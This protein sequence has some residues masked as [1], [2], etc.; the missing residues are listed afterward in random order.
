VKIRPKIKLFGYSTLIYGTANLLTKLVVITLVP[1]YTTYLS[2]NEVGLIVF[3]EMIE[4]FVVT[5]IPIGCINAMWRFLAEEKGY[6][7]NKIIISAFTVIMVSGLVIIFLLLFFQN[8]ISSFFGI[9]NDN[10]L[11]VFVFVS[12]FLQ[13]ISHFIYSLLQYKNQSIFYLIL[14]LVQFLSL[15]GLTIYLIV[16]SGQGIIGIYYAKTSVFFA[17][18]ICIIFI[19]IKNTRALPSF[20]FIKKILIFGLPMIP[21]MLLMP[22]LNV[23]DR[24]F[25]KLFTSLEEIGRYGIAYKFGMLIN[26]FLVIPINRSWG[27]QMFQVG[28]SK[29]EN[30]KIHQDLTFYYSYIGWFI[31]VGLSFFSDTIISIV[32]NKEYLAAAW[33]IPWVSLAYFVGGFKIFFL[34][35]ATLADRT[36]LLVKTGLL[37][38]ITNVCLNYFFI[39]NYGVEGAVLSTILSNLILILLLLNFTKSVNQFSWPMKKIVHGAI[40]AS[41][42]III[43]KTIQEFA[44]DYIFVVKCLLLIM[45]PILSIFTN[46]IGEKEMNGVRYLWS[47]ILKKVKFNYE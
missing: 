41:L 46:L 21:M 47:S 4:L 5:I 38:I 14:S 6:N 37:A 26:M 42:I 11:L 8:N 39:K 36:D 45:F 2:V 13:S 16:Y 9:P 28:K 18:F 12:C 15:V 27:P 35:S 43:F 24:Y 20:K 3:L 17:S 1:L 22:V 32:A 7:K 34:A 29:E 40:I 10:N 19:L 33:L 30:R 31:I 44:I 25:L 23:S